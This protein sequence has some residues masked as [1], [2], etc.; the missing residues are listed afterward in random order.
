VDVRPLR[1]LTDETFTALAR[2]VAQL[3][4]SAPPLRRDQLA[5]VVNCATNTVLLARLEG[6]IVGSLALVVFPIPTGIRAWIEDVVVD[7]NA[8]GHGIGTALTREAV[9]IARRA[10]ARSV[11]LTSRPSRVAANRLY[12]QLGFELRESKVYR[13]APDIGPD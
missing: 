2:L 10:G 5:N 4:A 1:E 11:D 3:S 9:R 7:E 8:R 6:E 13:L 12:E